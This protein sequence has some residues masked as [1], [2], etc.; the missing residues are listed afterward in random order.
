MDTHE[1]LYKY[2]F[3]FRSDHSTQQAIITLDNRITKCLDSECN[4]IVIGIF[5]DLKK[6]FDTVDH[7]ILLKKLYA[8]GIRGI[9]LKWIKSYLSDHSQYV[10]YDGVSSNIRHITRRVPQGSILG[11]H[12]FVAYMNDIFNVSEFLFTVLYANDTSILV[13]GSNYSDLVQ[14]LN[15]ELCL[16]TNWLKAN[17]LSL[18]VQKTFYMVFHRAR[19]KNKD[20]DTSI[21]CMNCMKLERTDCFKY[22]GVILDS[23]I[24]LTQHISYIKNKVSKGIGIMYKARQYLDKKALLNIY[25]S[26]IYPYFIYC[27]EVWGNASHCHLHPL[28]LLQKKIIRIMTFSPYLAHTETLFINLE[29]LPLD[30]L[31]LNKIAIMMY[32]YANDMLPSVMHELYKKN[33]EIHTYDTRNK[34]L[35]RIDSGQKGLNMYVNSYSNISARLWN[36]L[37]PKLNT[38]VSLYLSLSL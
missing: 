10:I 18:N 29:I 36:A 13:N 9:T 1:V 6:A 26:Y 22:L 30:K 8:Y 24:T 34:D 4:D 25:Y 31:I 15:N 28:F 3:G 5:L 23:N 37:M 14:L 27:I 33:N 19:M 32:K 38:N 35:F 2:Q 11:P 7:T 17:K 21:V 12:F 16:L 20:F